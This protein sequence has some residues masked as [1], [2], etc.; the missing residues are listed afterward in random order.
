MTPVRRRGLRYLALGAALGGALF[1]VQR[2]RSKAPS[3]EVLFHGT[4]ARA[5]A[6]SAPRPPPP[7]PAPS[8]RASVE[9]A[10]PEDESGLG[11]RELAERRLARARRTLD[12][13]LEAT[14]Y[15]PGSRPLSEHA[16]LAEARRTTTTTQ[17]LSRK[18]GKRASTRVTLEQ[19]RYFL[20]GDE[21]ARL[22]ISCAGSEGAVPCEIALAEARVAPSMPQASAIPPAAVAFHDDGQNGDPAA[23]DGAFS[24]LFAPASA[25]FG[26]YHGPIGV[27]L[28]LRIDGE[29]GTA[30]FDLQY[31]PAAPARFTGRVREALEDGSLCLYVEMSVDHPGR[32]VLHG[33][34]DD[35]DGKGF[36]FLEFNDLMARG[37]QEARLCLFGKLVR[38]EHARSPFVLRDLEGFLL[39]ED[40]YPDR[41]IVP[42][43]VG[44]VYTTKAYDESRFS[45]A[46]W[47]SDDKKRHVDEF[48]KDVAD[49]TEDLAEADKG[50]R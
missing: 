33:R 42:S 41:E 37:S 23:G 26:G 43:L 14:R 39:K 9:A 35:A 5:P 16:D 6:T 27:E 10:N 13:Y 50:P 30:R 12:T 47:Q 38:D 32:Y 8:P 28:S 21:A 3:E 29:E 1:L 44:P 11:P 4:S 25:G 17:P 40:A 36:A 22:T 34:A 48:T 20:V 7:R 15:P 45:D 31:T 49:A 18:D 19:D 24:T 46:E 2:C